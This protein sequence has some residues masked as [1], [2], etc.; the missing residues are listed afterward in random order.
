MSV[1]PDSPYDE[2]RR[3]LRLAQEDLTAAET[4]V[5]HQDHG[6]RNAGF[7]AQQAAEK[8]LKAVLVAFGLPVPRIHDL[9]ALAA[10]LPNDDTA[11]DI[12]ALRR[13]TPWAVAGLYATEGD[14][15]AKQEADG[16]LAIAKRTLDVCTALVEAIPHGPE[17]GA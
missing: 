16:L 7:L 3:W 9:G 8:S 17:S 15:L 13:L 5:T 12:A 2:A 6:L 10:Q 11:L 14:A 1:R 4:L